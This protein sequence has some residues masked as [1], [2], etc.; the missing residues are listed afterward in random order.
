MI[1]SAEVLLSRLR[2]AVVGGNSSPVRA[3]A[4]EP[5]CRARAG[6]SGKA[7]TGR[8]TE[9]RRPVAADAWVSW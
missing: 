2:L 7:P 3:A 6:L 9:V 8:R 4:H 1:V 5:G